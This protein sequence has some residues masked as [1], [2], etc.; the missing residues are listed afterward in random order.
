MTIKIKTA[1]ELQKLRVAGRLAAEVLEM[2]EPHIVPGVSTG[3]LN[4]IMHDYMVNQQG[5]VPATLNYHGFPASSCI[6][7]NHVVCH[8]IPDHNKKLKKGDIVNVDVTVIKDGYHGDTSRMFE[9]GEVKPFAHRLCQVAHECMWLGIEQVK[10]NATLYDVA[11]AIQ[12]HAEINN[13]SVVREYCGHGIGADFHEEPQV[14]HYAA[15]DLKNIVLKPGMV[16]TI[17]PMIN[18][19]K[20]DVKLLG[21][22]W[23]VVT[24]DRKLSAQW[25]H[26]LAVTEDGYEI[27]TMRKDEVPVLP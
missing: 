1:D 14:L 23:T 13:F 17:E 27:F 7:I 16:F 20:A 9:V 2:I 6:S 5:T 3:E 18:L 19:G 24:K 12:Q 25:E 11:Y 10:P 22:N 21:D 15:P 4:E 26:T 8:G